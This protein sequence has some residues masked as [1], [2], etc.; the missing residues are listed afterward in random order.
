MSMPFFSGWLRESEPRELIADRLHSLAG[1]R[2]YGAGPLFAVEDPFTLE[3]PDGVLQVENQARTNSCVGHGT[4]SILEW[5]HKIR[6]GHSIQLSRQFA[7]IESQK[8]AGIRGDNGSHVSAA[9]RVSFDKGCC[10]ESTWPFRGVYDTRV[11]DGAYE[12]AKRFR[13]QSATE[14]FT[15][16]EDDQIYLGKKIGGILLG[17]PWTQ[18]LVQAPRILEELNTRSPL[19]GFHCVCYPFLSTRTDSQG[20]HYAWMLN[21]HSRSWGNRG[22]LEVS[23][24]ARQALYDYVYRRQRVSEA[25]GLSDLTESRPT[26]II[27]M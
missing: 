1:L 15:S 17:I 23:P 10:L 21:S 7:Y 9:I 16:V 22:W 2:A 13:I 8:L 5:L 25:Y 27:E 24:N 12:D 26:A 19:V 3:D 4:S 11:P 18:Q 6:T 20:R 14:N